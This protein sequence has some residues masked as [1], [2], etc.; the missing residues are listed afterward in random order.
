MALVALCGALGL[1]C[2]VAQA[3]VARAAPDLTGV[4]SEGRTSVSVGQVDVVG[5]DGVPSEEL[6][7][8]AQSESRVF[9]SVRSLLGPGGPDSVVL[10]VPARLTDLERLLSRPAGS[11]AAV[12]AV[13]IGR[14]RVWINREAFAALPEVARTIVLRHETTHLVE[15][16]SGSDAVPLWLEEGF[17]EFVGYVGSGVRLDVAAEDLLGE[18]AAGRL[19]ARLPRDSDFAT[20][21]PGAA[22]TPV[23]ATSVAYHQAWTTCLWLADRIGVQGL[24]RLY[25]N[26]LSAGG[27][28]REAAVDRALGEVGITRAEL[29]DRWRAAL[30]AWARDGSRRA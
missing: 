27:A 25:A 26:V 22:G 24:L 15:N 12:A 28:D 7:A 10:V 3:P 11:L 6:L 5:L 18:V 9:H 1:G 8:L 2:G 21:V 16:A 23:V 14:D 4:P 17:A 30:S 20:A 13:A 29:L 19:P